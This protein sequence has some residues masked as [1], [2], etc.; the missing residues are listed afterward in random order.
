[1]RGLLAYVLRSAWACEEERD[2]QKAAEL[3]VRAARLMM[4]R[5]PKTDEEA[6]VDDVIIADL[7]R[8]ASAFEDAIRQC[9]RGLARESGRRPTTFSCW[10]GSGAMERHR[11][12][13]PL[14]GLGSGTAA[15]AFF[16]SPA[17]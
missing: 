1:M 6:G 2:A 5:E 12:P 7:F 15:G 17:W 10:N 3:R 9:D 4:T 13:Q 14:R 16:P 11:L 8:R